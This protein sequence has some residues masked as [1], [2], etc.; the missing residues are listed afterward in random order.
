MKDLKTY[1]NEQ[2][3]DLDFLSDGLNRTWGNENYRTIETSKSGYVYLEYEKGNY[4]TFIFLDIKDN[5][6]KKFKSDDSYDYPDY[7]DIEDSDNSWKEETFVRN[8]QNKT[9][10]KDHEELISEIKEIVDDEDSEVTMKY[11]ID[12]YRIEFLFKLK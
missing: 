5:L 12:K 2:R 1:I 6:N 9:V 11:D 3:I 4:A 8:M 7:L 10:F